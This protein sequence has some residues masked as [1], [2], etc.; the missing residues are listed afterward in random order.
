M[1]QIVLY[2]TTLLVFFF[3][4]NILTWGLNIQFGYTGILNFA[5]II[6]MALGAYVTGVFS[7]PVANGISGQTYVLG[8]SWP[9][10]LTLLMGGLASAAFGLVV[11]L[12]ALKRLRSDYMAI[13]TV[14]VGVIT[15]DFVGNTTG[16]FNG[17]DGLGGVPSPLQDRFSISYG[18]Y[19]WVFVLLAGVVM[20][21]MW[22]FAQRIENSPYGRTLRSIREDQD[23]AES[24]G[25]NTFKYRMSAM[26][27]GCFYAGIAGGLLIEYITA[28]NPSG[29][30]TGE[31]FVIW[32]A[33]LI[34]GT[35]NNWGAALG[36]LL[37]P[38]LF[39]EVTRFLPQVSNNPDL[40]PALR[41]IIVGSLLILVLWF[42]PQ[43]II[44]E[45]K[46]RFFDLPLRRGGPAAPIAKE[47]ANVAAG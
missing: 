9:F 25:K 20:L 45:K 47:G 21:G 8:L 22:W 30:T 33:L 26:V 41:N 12:I 32:T 27:I 6:F 7:L 15:Y 14:A 28:I 34:G 19:Q 35:G 2:A 36:A 40:I 13:V 31:T 46:W 10:P 16:L 44:P 23:V 4:N 43:G 39:Q 24:F 3:I 11:G 42:R 29:W 17:W 18:T 37:V 5:F 1:N 38:V